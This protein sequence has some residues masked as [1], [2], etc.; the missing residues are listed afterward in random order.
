M[1]HF[2]DGGPP[3]GPVCRRRCCTVCSVVPAR[4]L[5]FSCCCRCAVGVVSPKRPPACGRPGQLASCGLRGGMHATPVFSDAP[6]CARTHCMLSIFLLRVSRGFST[7]TCLCLSHDMKIRCARAFISCS[8]ELRHS[9]VPWP[10][11]LMA[12]KQ[13]Y[14]SPRA[15]PEAVLSLCASPTPR[16]QEAPQQQQ[17]PVCLASRQRRAA[18]GGRACWWRTVYNTPSRRACTY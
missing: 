12:R 9:M 8:S 3:P 1:H 17:Q 16:V 15:A 4:S 7:V 10:F 2:R 18:S 14:A 5:L 13:V 11:G 6:G